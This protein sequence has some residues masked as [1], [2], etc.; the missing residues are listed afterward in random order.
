VIVTDCS[1][2]LEVLL[3]TDY[4]QAVETRLFKAGE[5]LHAPHLIDVEAAHVLRRYVLY[6]GLEE[7]RARQAL[8]DLRDF[9][10]RRH[11]H[12]ILL[13]RIWELR[14]N[15]SAYDAAYIA[16]AEALDALLLTRD[17]RLAKAPGHQAR[18]EEIE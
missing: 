11:P 17:G 14:S 1:A 4:A 8:E 10:L 16:L 2:I 6:Q 13:S 18:I 5:T 3:Q 12:D 9:P 15:L 7:E